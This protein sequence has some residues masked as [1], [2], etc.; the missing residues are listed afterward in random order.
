M[1]SQYV[2]TASVN[3]TGSTHADRL[4][5][6]PAPANHHCDT[7]QAGCETT[8]LIRCPVYGRCFT[9]KA[10]NVGAKGALMTEK[11][12]VCID[13]PVRT[14]RITTRHFDVEAL[15]PR[16]LY[17]SPAQ[18][19]HRPTHGEAIVAQSTPPNDTVIHM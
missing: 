17:T 16:F 11:V 13:P 3:H 1:S 6:H 5:R 12:F 4:S 10:S 9:V 7:L 14:M 8:T 18:S 2:R 15:S 19:L